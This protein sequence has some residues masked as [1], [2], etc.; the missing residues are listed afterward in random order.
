MSTNIDWAKLKAEGR[1]KDIGLA[2]NDEEKK[3]VWELKIPAD[4]VRRGA[5]TTEAYQKL[6]A[7]DQ[8]A[9]E[10]NG[11]LPI[12]AK[13]I[14]QLQVTAKKLKIQVAP[15]APREVLIREITRTEEANKAEAE[16]KAKAKAEAAAKAKAKASK[17]KKGK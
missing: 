16:A 2:W 9:V 8:K 1:V 15:E 11:D 17:D 7:A 4:F 6:V 10:K 3:A 5:L 13:T 12:E 14:K